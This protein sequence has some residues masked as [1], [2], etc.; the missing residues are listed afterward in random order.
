MGEEKQGAELNAELA[1]SLLNYAR[2]AQEQ[3]YAP[4]SRYPVGAAVLTEDGSVFTGANIEN[5]SYGLT[6]CAERVA[7]FKAVSEG[8]RRLAAIAVVGP[9]EHVSPPCG[10]CRQV[11]A[12]FA[13]ELPVILPTADPKQHFE[14]VLLTELL[15]RAFG[16]GQL[17]G[18][19]E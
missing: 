6:M 15:P 16:P 9:Q 13:P 7:L 11:L 12:E 5:A 10:S 19:D 18:R 8:H 3:A 14:V 4:Y 17:S 1:E 2:A